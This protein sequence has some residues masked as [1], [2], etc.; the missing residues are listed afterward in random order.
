MRA[1]DGWGVQDSGSRRPEQGAGQ[2]RSEAWVCPAL[3][4]L[5]GPSAHGG[6]LRCGLWMRLGGQPGGWGAAPGRR[7]QLDSGVA[8]VSGKEPHPH[9]WATDCSRLGCPHEEGVTKVPDAPFP[10]TDA[11]SQALPT[12]SSWWLAVER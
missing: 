4:Q 9:T 8:H 6:A 12:A 7:G 3:K 5:T 2:V 10:D 11:L 1:V